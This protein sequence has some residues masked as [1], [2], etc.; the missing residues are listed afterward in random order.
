LKLVIVGGLNAEQRE[1]FD[2]AAKRWQQVIRDAANGISL[3]LVIRAEG[4]RIDGP[5]RVLGR[6]GPTRIRLSDSLPI[7]GIM[8]FD[9]AVRNEI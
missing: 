2:M 5:G 7:E 3:K 6:A 1:I 8:E 4:Q 9:Q